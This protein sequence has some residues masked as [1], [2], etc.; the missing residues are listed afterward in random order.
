MPAPCSSHW[1]DVQHVIRYLKGA[2]NNGM[3]FKTYA[4]P[5]NEVSL[6]SYSNVDWEGDVLNRKSIFDHYLHLNEEVSDIL[7]K[8]LMEM[9]FIPYRNKLGVFSIEEL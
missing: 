7:T 5:T 8:Q 1:T 4:S 2:L 9:S 3:L 6:V